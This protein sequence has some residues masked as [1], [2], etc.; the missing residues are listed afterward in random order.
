MSREYYTV[1]ELNINNDSKERNI[2]RYNIL[3]SS[4]FQE[5]PNFINKEGRDLNFHFW[6]E[7][8]MATLYL[9]AQTVNFNNISEK[10]GLRCYIQSLVDLVPSSVASKLIENFITNNSSATKSIDKNKNLLPENIRA[11]TRGDLFS[12]INDKISMFIFAYLLNCYLSENLHGQTPNYQQLSDKWRAGNISKR[13]WGRA[14]W[15]VIH[16]SAAYPM[17]NNNR[18]NN[19]W[20]L[21]YTAMI[22]CLRFLLPCP[23][24]RIHLEKNLA[25][26][27]IN[28][29]TSN[30]E[31]I[32]EW[33]W[34]LHNIVNKDENKPQ[35]PL[36][37]AKREYVF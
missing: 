6:G 21:A 10:K 31:S 36:S 33:S 14:F 3:G 8:Y 11:F 5:V 37:D 34:M 9:M 17:T 13:D 24:C 25:L 28:D 32:F 18:L 2:P 19:S 4:P 30:Q 15:F 26:L 12:Q 1:S 7:R 22:V 35:Y 16:C 29:Y 23:K 27:K 20:I